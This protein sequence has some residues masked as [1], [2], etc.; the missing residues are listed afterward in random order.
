MVSTLV[1]VGVNQC[2]RLLQ[3]N[4]KAGGFSF[5]NFIYSMGY[6]KRNVRDLN[7]HSNAYAATRFLMGLPLL[8][9]RTESP[10]P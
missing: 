1:E 2:S 6:E 8:L 10:V 7:I 9:V 3:D 4:K 5:E